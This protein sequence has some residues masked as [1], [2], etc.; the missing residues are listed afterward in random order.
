VPIVENR[1]IDRTMGGQYPDLATEGARSWPQRAA[2]AIETVLD[3]RTYS[4]IDAFDPTSMADRAMRSMGHRG[5]FESPEQ[6]FLRYCGSNPGG[7]S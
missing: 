2:R 5:I 6:H 7:C 1:S 3:S 4:I